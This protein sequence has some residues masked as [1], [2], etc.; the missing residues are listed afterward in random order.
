M[1]RKSKVSYWWWPPRD[2]SILHI[3]NRL[4]ETTPASPHPTSAEDRLKRKLACLQC[5]E[6]VIDFILDE[7]LSAQSGYLPHHQSPC[8]SQRPPTL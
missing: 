7:F 6:F 4:R 2:G 8:P 5:L 1:P 3:T